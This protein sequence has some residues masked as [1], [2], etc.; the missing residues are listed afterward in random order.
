MLLAQKSH[1]SEAYQVTAIEMNGDANGL[2]YLVIYMCVYFCVNAGVLYAISV[3]SI[4]FFYF[5][6]L[7]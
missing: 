2:L 6:T 3:I 7:V 1:N 4:Q 5:S